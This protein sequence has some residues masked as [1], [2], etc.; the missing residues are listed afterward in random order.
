MERTNNLLALVGLKIFNFQLLQNTHFQSIQGQT[1][2]QSFFQFWI[3]MI[4][5]INFDTVCTDM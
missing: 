3:E 5:R 1:T 2:F 4:V